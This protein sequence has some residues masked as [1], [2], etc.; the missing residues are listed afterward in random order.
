MPDPGGRLERRLNRRLDTRAALARAGESLPAVLQIV[1]AATLAYVITHDLLDHSTPAVALIST[2]TIL[3]FSRDARPK[4]VLESAIGILTGIVLS[5]VA[6][7]IVGSGWWQIALVLALTLLVARLLSPSAPFAIAAGV[8]ATLVMVMPAPDGGVF[9]RSVDGLVGGVV[10]LAVTAL[11]PRDPR[12]IARRDARRMV[13][14]LR[15]SLDSLIE[16]LRDAHE[17]AASLALTRL[18]RTQGFLDAW[19]Q[20]QESAIAIARISPFLRR[21]LPTLRYQSDVLT[22]LDL[23]ARHLRVITRR[24]AFLVRDGERR[25]ALAALFEPIAEAVALLGESVQDPALALQA[26]DVLLEIMPTLDP[27][28]TL[29]GA[30]M[31]TS[32]IVHLIR[33]LAVDLLVATGMQ[34][35]EARALL[36]EV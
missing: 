30:R 31:P 36:P 22:G 8:Q 21:H 29:P 11:F 10:A 17:P 2:I 25:P 5:E 7:L 6:F 32:I 14:T 9:T 4:R 34:A 35:D 1:I 20:S 19:S 3:G 13:A 15:E 33:P 23:A 27:A 24:V 26:R 28:A 16:A 12:R 18:R